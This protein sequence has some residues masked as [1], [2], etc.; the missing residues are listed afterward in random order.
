M[1]YVHLWS[2]LLYLIRG[3]NLKQHRLC[4]HDAIHN[5]QT[6]LQDKELTAFDVNSIAKSRQYAVKVCVDVTLELLTKC[7]SDKIKTL[8]LWTGIGTSLQT[9][10]L[11]KLWN[12]PEHEARDIVDVLWGYGLIQF[13]DIIVPP[14]NNT[15]SCLEVHAVISQYLIECIDSMEVHTLSLF[16][17][18][19]SKPVNEE[20]LKNLKKLS[21]NI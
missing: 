11:H 6:K 16:G 5:V 9:A 10:V 17:A 3:H 8:I 4:N 14:H 1:N 13:T 2:L 18:G 7:S 12:I 21:W 15:Q 19:T 20:L